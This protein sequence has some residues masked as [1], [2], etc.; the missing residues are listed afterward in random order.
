MTWCLPLLDWRRLSGVLRYAKAGLLGAVL[1]LG[2][3]QAAQAV[4]PPELFVKP[5]PPPGTSVEQAWVP[6]QPG[7]KLLPRSELGARIHDDDVGGYGVKTLSVPDGH[8]NGRW[9]YPG[10]AASSYGC[11]RKGGHPGDIVSIY[12]VEWEGNGPYQVQVTAY[13]QSDEFTCPEGTSTIASYS[14]DL[15]VAGRAVGGPLI[16]G[17]APRSDGK[18]HGFAFEQVDPAGPGS[19]FG[20]VDGECA[21]SAKV[22]ADGSLVAVKP[23]ELGHDFDFDGFV[24]EEDLGAPGKW[25]CVARGSASDPYDLDQTETTAWSAPVTAFVREYFAPSQFKIVDKRGPVFAVSA[26]LPDRFSGGGRFTARL[27]RYG[28]RHP[29]KVRVVHGRVKGRKLRLNFR[30]PKDGCW[31]GTVSFAGT[32][33]VAPGRTDF[34][35]DK[36]NGHPLDVPYAPSCS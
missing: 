11:S 21:R 9:D 10:P 4:T 6:F 27:Q 13:P 30:L 35:V 22:A 16:T 18:P 2:L 28:P 29:G 15:E 5:P 33:L 31:I 32:R 26:R 3:P 8:P 7:A 34:L 17:G 20:Q 1:A 23:H 19:D 36:E 24:A 14:I 12:H 25:T